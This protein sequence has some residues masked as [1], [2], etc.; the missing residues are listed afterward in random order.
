[1]GPL[2][3]HLMDLAIGL[4]CFLPT[5]AIFAKVLLPRIEKAL[6]AREDAIDGT[7][8][9]ARAVHEEARRIHAEYQ[10]ELSA[11]RHEAARIRQTAAEEGAA[12]LASVRAEGQKQRDALVA[13]A[14]AQLEADLIIAEVE[15]REDVFNL[16]TALAGRIVGEPLID[17]PKARAISDEFF[18]TADI[19]SSA[20]K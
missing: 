16:A 8:E 13:A 19:K 12:L 20:T 14:R 2:T 10:A 9:R 5:F 6:K 1:M 7:V 15:L 18:A 17:L 3:P 4:I 11:A